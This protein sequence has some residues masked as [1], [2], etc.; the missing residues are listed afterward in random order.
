MVIIDS[1]FRNYTFHYFRSSYA[2]LI[3]SRRL[4]REVE[5]NGP[6]SRNGGF[7]KKNI[8]GTMYV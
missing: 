8:E 2:W 6:Y 4:R 5:K 7:S 3:T 1:T